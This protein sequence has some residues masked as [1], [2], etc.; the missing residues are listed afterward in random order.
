MI[1]PY[2][3]AESRVLGADCILLIVA[4]LQPAQLKEL[5][6]YAQAIAIDVLVEVHNR[7]ELDLALELDTELIGIN[8]RD[9]HSFDTSLDT[10]LELA[11]HIPDERLIITES[12]IHVAADVA[13]MI[14][15]NIYGFLVGESLMRAPSPGAKLAELFASY[16]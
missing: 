8:N 2:Q 11:R 16:G 14:D 10:T 7:E 6:A 15:N 12:G 3:I 9:L 1:D 5:A 13:R 4:A